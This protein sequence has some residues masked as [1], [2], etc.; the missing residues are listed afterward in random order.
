[1]WNGDHLFLLQHLVIKDFKIRY[2]NM[3][4]G[5]FW[6][7]LNPLILMGVLTFIF[8]KVFSNSGIPH[9]GVFVLC[10]LVQFNFFSVAWNNGTTSVAFNAG[11]IKKVPVPREVIPISSVLSNCVHLLIQIGLLL[12]FVLATGYGVNRHWV[13][14]PVVWIFEIVFVCGLVLVTTSL[15]VYIRDMRYVVES[16]TTIL[17]WLVPIFYPF[18]I[19]PQQFK[20]VYQFNPVAALVMALRNIL[21]EAKAPPDSLLIKL[22]LVSCFTFAFG[23][24]FFGR[25]KR[26]FFDCL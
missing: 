23:L 17:F 19:I 2:R 4:L 11:L 3:S 13:W 21:L 24:W 5:V 10:G 25:L 18:S 8:T 12:T 14:L 9:F 1:M 6:S 26:R 22:T 16:T 7:L 15:D 20:E